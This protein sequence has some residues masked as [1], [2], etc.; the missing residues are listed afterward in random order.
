MSSKAMTSG[1]RLR[2]LA[3]RR[4]TSARVMRDLATR[5]SDLLA[6]IDAAGRGEIETDAV[7]SVLESHLAARAECLASMTSCDD[8]WA[9][10]ATTLHEMDALD[11][12]AIQR[13][14]AEIGGILAEL[15]TSDATFAT[16]L[17]ARR[18]AAGAEIARADGSRAA[19]RAYA[20]QTQ[21]PRFTDRRG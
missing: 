2:A 14:S 20:P 1:T 12:D 7:E 15:T 10:A 4:L 11:R 8:E 3:E 17:S 6:A 19:H 13:I 9:A 18:R 16:E 5:Q 21:A